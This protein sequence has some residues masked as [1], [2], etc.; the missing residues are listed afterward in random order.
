MG[1]RTGV[2][3]SVALC[4]R[5]SG[6]GSRTRRSGAAAKQRKAAKKAA[7]VK[8]KKPAAKPRR[9]ASRGGPAP[10]ERELHYS[11]L[12]K[13]MLASVLKRLK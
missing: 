2:A 7:V 12:R 3:S 10:E 1:R 8:A 5:G 11:D 9:A 13:V 6:H 4:D